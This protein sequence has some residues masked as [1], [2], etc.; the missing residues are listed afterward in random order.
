MQPLA[1]FLEEFLHGD[2]PGFDKVLFQVVEGQG[3]TEEFSKVTGQSVVVGVGVGDHYPV[4]L[5]AVD[6]AFG[7]LFF[8]GV[9]GFFGV[10][11]GINEKIAVIVP[12]QVGVDVVQGGDGQRQWHTVY[13]RCD[14]NHISPVI[15]TVKGF[16]AGE[17][18]LFSQ[19]LLDAE[20]AVVLGGALGA[21]GSAGLD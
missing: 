9:K 10:P 19:F 18:G 17:G 13:T 5:F 20:Q 21:A 16:H 8:E 6:A 1:Q 7:Q 14:L 4:N 2:V 3:G 15:L 12:D 11:A